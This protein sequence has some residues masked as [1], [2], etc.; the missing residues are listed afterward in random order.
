MNNKQMLKKV[1]KAIEFLLAGKKRDALYVLFEI[2]ARLKE[3]IEKEESRKEDGKELQHL[4]GW[5]MKV[6]NDRPP[7]ADRFID[8]KGI[9]GKHL[10]ELSQIFKRDGKSLEDL[11]QLYESFKKSKK[12]Y[13]GILEFR[14]ELPNLKQIKSN[15]WTSP[16][17]R[18]GKDFYLK[19]WAKD[20]DEDIPF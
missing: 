13:N 20:D 2:E 3:E 8:Y 5:Y 9:I 12:T 6:W 18:R 4:M 14:R 10:K 11:K 1:E 16:E 15:E 7:E 17:N 19:D